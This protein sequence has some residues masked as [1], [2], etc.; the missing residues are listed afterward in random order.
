MYPYLVADIGGTNARFAIV[1]G[2]EAGHYQFQHITKLN[3]RDYSS[4][5][6]A[7]RSYLDGLEV[8]SP[9]NACVAV[10]GPIDDNSIKMTNLPWAFSTAGLT[11]EFSFG[12]VE[13][14]NDFAALAVS[15]SE[16]VESQ[17]LL[18]K[19]GEAQARSSKAIL[20]PGTGLGVA[21]LVNASGVW[22]PIASEG[23]HV[24]LSPATALEC[25]VIAAGMKR[26]G[27]VSAEVFISGPGLVNLY[28]ALADV[29][30]EQAVFT[31]PQQVSS[32]AMAGDD[33]LSRE[34]LELFCSF[35]GDFSGN[36]ALTY[37]AKGGVY[38][39]GGILPR[40]VDFFCNSDFVARFSEKGIMSDYLTDIPVNLIGYEYAAL[41][42]AAAWLDQKVTA[43]HS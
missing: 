27:H 11:E 37:G 17:M 19:P 41:L 31:E 34:S 39:A 40:F 32:A 30:G 23:G 38:L 7:L 22:Q 16:L 9:R 24:N 2:K 14:M 12:T 26:Y 3:G 1:T 28:S 36:L 35:L 8:E 5:S 29:R 10:A 15:T 33:R 43:T 21:Q 6:A 20:G 18:V 13:L 4:F 42:G 25:E